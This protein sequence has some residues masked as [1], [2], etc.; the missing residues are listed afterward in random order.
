MVGIGVNLAATP[1]D[2]VN[3]EDTLLLAVEVG[4]LQDDLRV[5]GL[6]AQWIGVH[7]G[8]INADRLVRGDG[9]SIR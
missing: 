4:M 1:I 8:R 9:D 2:D 5:L 6:I 7:H 3:I